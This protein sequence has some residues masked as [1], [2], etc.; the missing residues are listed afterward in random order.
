MKQIDPSK[1]KSLKK[2]TGSELW[3]MWRLV[4]ANFP[5][6][7]V[8]SKDKII[9]LAHLKRTSLNYFDFQKIVEKAYSLDKKYNR[10]G[11]IFN[12][13]RKHKKDKPPKQYI[14]TLFGKVEKK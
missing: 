5:E 10:I 2:Q 9:W 3:D 8:K 1:F 12:Q 6:V 11:Y 7:Q 14:D 4:I 13:V